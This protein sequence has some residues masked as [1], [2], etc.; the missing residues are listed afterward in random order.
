MLTL[1]AGAPAGDIALGMRSELLADDLPHFDAILDEALA[2]QRDYLSDTEHAIYRQGK[3]LRPAVLLLAARMIH[4]PEPLPHKVQQGAVSL[5]MLHVATLIH[6]DIVD[7]SALRRGLPSVNAA[8]GTE[9]AVLV[10]DLQFV[11]A[12]RGFVRAIDR[13]SDMAL[14]ELV[15][16]T[17]FQIGC[18][19]LDELRTDMNQTPERLVAHY[20]RT[21][22]RKTAVLFGLAAEA[23]VT[24]AGGR[25][26]D[27][28]RAGFCGRRLGRALQVMDDL[29]DLAQDE[30]GSGK[31]RGMDL[32]RRRASLPLVYAMAELGPQHRVSRVLRGEPLDAES[33]ERCVAE[34]RGTTGFARAY[35][36]AR[37][38]ALEAIELL[39][40]FPAN[41]YRYAL[42]DLALHIVDRRP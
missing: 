16:D 17:A 26:S 1:D 3:R 14:I 8:R 27:A 9:A 7:D 37:T 10:G 33:L 6:D 31:P 42:E 20:W 35:A 25:T 11:Q 18:G 12:I 30:A 21:C 4:G 29:F 19:E 23:G 13:D 41:R 2:P 24:L 36:D 22:D 15:L 38:Q 32:L 28:R 39:R 5:E 40:P 34:V